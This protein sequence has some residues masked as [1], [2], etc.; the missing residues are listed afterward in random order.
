[1]KID[2]ENTREDVY[3]NFLDYMK[4]PETKRMYTRN[5]GKFL[6]LIPNKI[7]VEYL[8]ESPKSWEIK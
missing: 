5:L 2:M 7:F 1:M 8:G 3:A 6:N 4:S